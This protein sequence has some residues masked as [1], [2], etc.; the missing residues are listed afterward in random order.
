[1][2][3]SKVVDIT[4]EQL[5]ELDVVELD[6]ILRDQTCTF[7]LYFTFPEPETRCVLVVSLHHSFD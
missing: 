5:K 4:V 1:M 7:V 6:Q 2:L 3:T